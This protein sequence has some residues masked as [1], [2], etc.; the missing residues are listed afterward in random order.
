MRLSVRDADT[1]VQRSPLRMQMR[2]FRP[3]ALPSSA[4]RRRLRPAPRRRI[5]LLCALLLRLLLLLRRVLRFQLSAGIAGLHPEDLGGPKALVLRRLH[6][7]LRVLRSGEGVERRLSVVG[8]PPTTPP[9][10]RAGSA[11][12]P[13]LP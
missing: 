7:L 1:E 13:A 8:R 10:V 12:A 5:Q 2:F 3:M 6:L 4:L 11:G 9:A